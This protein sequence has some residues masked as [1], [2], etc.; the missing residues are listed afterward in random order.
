MTEICDKYK[1]ALIY[2]I[3]GNSNNYTN[4]KCPN[5]KTRYYINNNKD[6]DID[7]CEEE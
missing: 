7:Y 5:C 2:I 3:E 1:T 4:Y 6:G